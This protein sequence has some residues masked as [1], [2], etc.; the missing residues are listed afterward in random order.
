MQSEVHEKGANSGIPNSK[1]ERKKESSLRLVADYGCSFY[2]V[3]YMIVVG[4]EWFSIDLW[5]SE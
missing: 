4:C 3:P 1:Y 5:G 2:T